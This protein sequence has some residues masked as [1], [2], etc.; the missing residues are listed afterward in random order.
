MIAIASLLV[1]IFVSLI[2][3]RVATVALIAT[4]L[5]RPRARFQ[6]RSAFTGVGF[7]TGEAEHVVGHPVRR[8]II[9][10]LM[11]IGNAGVAAVMASIVLTFLDARGDVAITPRVAILAGGLF[12]LVW[13][14]TSS[15]VDRVATRLIGKMLD[16]YTTLPTRDVGGLLELDAGYRV[17]ELQ[18]RPSDWLADRDLAGVDLFDEGV[19]V[20]GIRREGGRYLG[21]PRGE[22]VIHPGDT[23]VLYGRN[24]VLEQLD[25]RRAGIGGELAHVDAVAEH[26]RSST[27][28]DDDNEQDDEDEDE[29][30]RSS[31][32]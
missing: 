6:A 29:D 23:L 3:T 21:A 28:T 32:G 7:T 19:L 4:G 25:D 27:E 9:S 31:P 2:I 13:I 10:I 26:R 11:L 17:A 30:S 16:R 15:R 8:R 5:S 24:T 12:V 1:I 22:A 14:A 20:L 18:V